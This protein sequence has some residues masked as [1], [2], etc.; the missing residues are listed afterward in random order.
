M[1]LTVYGWQSKR[2]TFGAG[3]AADTSGKVAAAVQDGLPSKVLSV[4]SYKVG[5]N[6]R[7][8][9]I[10]KF[11]GA[12]ELVLL[13]HTGS[14]PTPSIDRLNEE[15]DLVTD[16]P[17]RLPVSATSWYL[18]FRIEISS[19]FIDPTP[20]DPDWPFTTSENFTYYLYKNSNTGQVEGRSEP[21]VQGDM[22]PLRNVQCAFYFKDVTPK[23]RVAT[24]LTDRNGKLQTRLP[25]GQYE[26]EF[27][28]GGMNQAQWL[29]DDRAI[30]VGAGAA[31]SPWTGGSA[32]D[33]AQAAEFS[34]IRSQFSTLY[35]PGYM[36][37]EDFSPSRS[38]YRDESAESNGSNY[39]NYAMQAFGRVFAGVSFVD[40]VGFAIDP[41][42]E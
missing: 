15:L 39:T 16:Y 9:L 25:A 7:I 18:S 10:A 36:V 4:M 8:R 27:Y 6:D 23:I 13:D 12:Q 11:G 26:V 22:V 38:G 14:S 41:S 40:F 21:I 42:P 30:S 28:G 2:Y 31:V 5:P 34:F 1:P 37:A 24:V 35:W 3:R 33:V 19:N 20:E 17:N 32:S 29:L